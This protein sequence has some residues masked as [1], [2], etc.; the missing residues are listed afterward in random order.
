[1]EIT[2]LGSGTGIPS[3][4]RGSPG[5][6]VRLLGS[7][8]AACESVQ[9]G[10]DG[11]STDAGVLRGPRS[12]TPLS[13]PLTSQGL[14]MDLGP[15]TCRQLARAGLNTNDVDC[16]LLTHLHPDHANDLVPF[17]FA[18]RYGESRTKP[19]MLIGPRGFKLYHERLM[20]MFGDPAASWGR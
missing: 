4:K 20:N 6:L 10:T 14:L 9:P 8:G 7:D 15:G 1:M 2:L 16:I 18:A 5:I 11:N 19:L 13:N 3:A 12:H 17:F